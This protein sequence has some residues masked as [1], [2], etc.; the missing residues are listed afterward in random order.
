MSLHCFGG[1]PHNQKCKLFWRVRLHLHSLSRL[2]VC[3]HSIASHM[4]TLSSKSNEGTALCEYL[5]RAMWS[6][7]PHSVKRRLSHLFSLLHTRLP[8]AP[9]LR[10]SGGHPIEYASAT[11]YG[12]FKRWPACS[13]L[14]GL[15][16]CIFACILIKEFHLGNSI[17]APSIIEKAR[18]CSLHAFYRCMDVCA[19]ISWVQ[20]P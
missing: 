19:H 12:T 3:Y 15:K 5:Y 18:I 13:C 14:A 10:H 6:A 1:N 4:Q 16:P 17:V 20:R 2:L 7:R 9:G 8:Y 11:L